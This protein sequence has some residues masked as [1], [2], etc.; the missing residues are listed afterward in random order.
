MKS[1]QKFFL[2]LSILSALILGYLRFA[3]Y[4]A[5]PNAGLGA[6]FFYGI[7]SGLVFL[8]GSVFLFIFSVS[9]LK[10]TLKSIR[11][12]K[13]ANPAVKATSGLDVLKIVVLV[14][15]VAISAYPF[16]Y[17]IVSSLVNS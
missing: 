5:G 8:I 6:A 4:K 2:S 17:F 1:D 16:V 12:R 14:I 10:D 3:D 9:M 11:I 15:L 7:L 13:N